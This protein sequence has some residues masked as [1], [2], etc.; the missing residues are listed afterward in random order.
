M[1]SAKLPDIYCPFKSE[2]SQHAEIAQHEAR[3]WAIRFGLLTDSAAQAKFDTYKYGWLA[4]RSYPSVPMDMLVLVT[5]WM[6]WTFTFD[7]YCDKI[8]DK[9]SAR[10]RACADAFMDVLNDRAAFAA[11]PK[12]LMLALQDLW[13]KTRRGVPKD[14]AGRFIGNFSDYLDGNV[15]EADCFTNGIIPSVKEYMRMRVYT[16]A[17]Y[18]FI[19]LIE[20]C[21]GFFLPSRMLQSEDFKKVNMLTNRSVCWFN[22]FISYQKEY[23]DGDI[24]NLVILIHREEMISISDAA[25]KVVLLHN[26][27]IQSYIDIESKILAEYALDNRVSRYV[28]GLRSWI[29]GDMDWSYESQ[30]YR[31]EHNEQD[32]PLLKASAGAN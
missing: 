7:D 19:D 6:I 8:I 18:V 11:G 2:L 25:A 10:V 20:V 22:D 27:D 13:L 12:S 21:E 17:M 31:I 9:N 16:I 30:R 32:S 29:R 28:A 23:R 26:D 24:Q 3:E 4:A 15:W 5:C 1:K 14:W